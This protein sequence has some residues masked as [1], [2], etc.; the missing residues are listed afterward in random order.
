[1]AL[2]N[3]SFQSYSVNSVRQKFW[4]DE[5]I[6]SSQYFCCGVIIPSPPHVR[7]YWR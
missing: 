5:K 4:R 1:M 2:L 3:K 6:L 7:Q